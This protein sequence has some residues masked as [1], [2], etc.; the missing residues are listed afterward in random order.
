[1]DRILTFIWRTT[2]HFVI[3][4]LRFHL[5]VDLLNQTV[6]IRSWQFSLDISQSTFSLWDITSRSNKYI[7]VSIG[8]VIIAFSILCFLHF[9][10]LHRKAPRCIFFLHSFA[11]LLVCLSMQHSLFKGFICIYCLILSEPPLGKTIYI[12]L[13]QSRYRFLIIFSYFWCN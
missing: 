7:I 6:R 12:R 4:W 11:S 2:S 9:H 3:A 13:S 1:M 8:L 10:N 5:I